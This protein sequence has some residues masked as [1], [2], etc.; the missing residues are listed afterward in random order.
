MPE[1]ASST[2]LGHPASPPAQHAATTDSPKLR[3]RV[4]M[5]LGSLAAVIWGCYIAMVNHGVDSGLA[6]GDLAVLRYGTAAVLLLPWLLRHSP[7]TLAGIGWPRGIAL[8]MLAGPVFVLVG[9]SGFLYA[10]LAH[11][12]VIQLGAVALVGVILSAWLI[13]ERPTR[14]GVLGMMIVVAGLGIIAGPGLLE[15]GSAVWK[16]DLLFLTAGSM[17]ALFTVLQRRWRISPMAATAVVSVLSGLIYLPLYLALIGPAKLMSLSL[18]ILLPQV[19][20]LGVLSGVV[21]LFAFSRAVE[22]LGPA[23]ASLFPAL[24]PA[25][26]ILA[27]VPISGTLPTALQLLG[28][29][30]LSA[31]MFV[32]VRSPDAECHITCGPL[33]RRRRA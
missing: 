29:L 8:A 9:A 6:A 25:I 27:G 24:A 18:S 32:A 10:P 13:G 28:L 23:R 30:V 5:A 33:R 21:A 15:S 2:R 4:G 1:S 17:W 7:L 16:G 3:T 19:L 12:A 31:G 14:R 20:V 26:A 22:Y 11:S